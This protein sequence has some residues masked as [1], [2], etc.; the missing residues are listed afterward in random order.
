MAHGARVKPH[1]MQQDSSFGGCKKVLKN[2]YCPVQITDH[3]METIGGKSEAELGCISE[4]CEQE[5]DED[6]QCCKVKNALVTQLQD[7]R[8]TAGFSE[9]TLTKLRNAVGVE[10]DANAGPKT[11]PEKPI[12]EREAEKRKLAEQQ[13]QEV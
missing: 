3:L 9:E 4:F 1:N 8:L 5:G 11:A 13:V 2:N 6:A 7:A 10:A 12:W